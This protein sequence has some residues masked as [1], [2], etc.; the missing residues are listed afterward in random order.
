MK[1]QTLALLLSCGAIATAHAVIETTGGLLVDIDAA[2][3]SLLTDDTAVTTW[4]N[5][6]SQPDFRAINGTGG[7]TF[8][9]RG[10]IHVVRF[11]NTAAHTM[12]NGPLGSVPSSIL[13]G[14]DWS[15]EV[16]LFKEASGGGATIFS[17]TPR[18]GIT[19]NTGTVMELRPYDANNF[20]EH[21]GANNN[22][23]WGGV[24]D[25]N[26]PLYPYGQ[27][28]HIAVT[29]EADGRERLYCDGVMTTEAYLPGTNLQGDGG[30]FTIGAVRRR[31][32]GAWVNTFAGDVAQIR[33]HDGALTPG[34]VL[35]NYHSDNN[36]RYHRANAQ[37]AVW[38]TGGWLDLIPAAPDRGLWILGGDPLTVSAPLT[39]PHL[40][41]DNGALTIANGATLDVTAMNSFSFGY[42]NGS[43]F[44]LDI[45]DG[46]LAISTFN[47][48]TSYNISFGHCVGATATVT[49]GNGTTPAALTLPCNLVLGNYGGTADMTILNGS[50]LTSRSRV[51]VGDRG[52]TGT[53]DIEAGGTSISHDFII[54]ALGGTGTVNV[55]GTLISSNTLFIGENDGGTGTLT[56]APGGAVTAREIRPYN[57][58]GAGLLIFDGG[59]LIPTAN[60]ATAFITGNAQILITENGATFDTP[61][62]TFVTASVPIQN[63]T[64]ATPGTLTKTGPGELTLTGDLSALTGDIAVEGGAL[65]FN[66]S[67]LPDTFPGT[68]HLTDGAQIGYDSVGGATILL[69]CL[70][71][72]S[73]GTLRLY[74]NNAAETIDLSNHPGITLAPRGTVSQTTPITPHGNH[75]IFTPNGRFTYTPPIAD[76]AGGAPARV[77]VRGTTEDAQV[78]LTGDNAG[79]TGGITVESGGLAI[80]HPNAAGAAAA[81][82][83][84]LAEGTTLKLAAALPAD[85]LQTRVTDASRPLQILLTPES[86]ACDIDATRFPGCFLGTE[87]AGTVTFT[88]ALT[89]SGTDYLLGGG[90][91]PY[92]SPNNGLAIG[93]LTDAPG[94]AARRAVLGR[95]GLV[96][97]TNGNTHSGGT[98]VTNKAALYLCSDDGLGA[99]PA[100]LTLDG[101][102]LRSGSANF[103]LPAE[104]GILIGPAGAILH[105]WG[106]WTMTMLGNL[107]GTGPVRI[108]D[109]GSVIAAG[110]AN[111]YNGTVAIVSTLA[112][113]GI[114]NGPAFSWASTGGITNNGILALNTD[115]PATFADTI[116]G[117]GRIRKLGSGTLDITAAHPFTGRTVIEDGTLRLSGAGS[118]ANNSL[119]VNHG[120]LIIA[121]DAASG[122]TAAIGSVY[123]GTGTVRVAGSPASLLLLE[124]YDFPPGSLIVEN[125]GT[126]SAATLGALGTNDIALNSGT[127]ALSAAGVQAFDGFNTSEWQIN[128][129]EGNTATAFELIDGI[130]RLYLT[131]NAGGAAASAFL[132]K[133]VQVDKT[134]VAEFD[135]LTGAMSGPA[136][137]FAFILHTDPRGPTALG[138]SGGAIGMGSGTGIAAISKSIGFFINIYGNDSIGWAQNGV[139]GTATNNIF[140][141]ANA[142]QDGNVHFKLAYDGRTLTLTASQAG[143]TWT[144][145]RAANLI[146][147][148]GDTTAW[149]GFT[150]GTG[151][152]TCQQF[153]ANPTFACG[154]LPT[155]DLHPFTDANWQRNGDATFTDAA[156]LRITRSA[157]SLASAT[158]QKQKVDISRPFT[159]TARYWVSEKSGNPA[160]GAAFIFQN[161]SLTSIGPNGSNLGVGN[162]ATAYG[163]ALD[164]YSNSRDA[165]VW[166]AAGTRLAGYRYENLKTDGITLDSG[167]PVD[168]VISYDL[169]TMRITV[170]Q[171]G[172]T[173]S[174]ESP[175]IDL[176]DT[177]G[178]KE[179]YFGITGGTGGETAEQYVSD[180]TLSYNTMPA[181]PDN[182]YPNIINASGAS[183]LAIT[184]RA[185]ASDVAVNEITLAAAA[186]LAVPAADLP[187]TLTANTLTVNGAGASVTVASNGTLILG[188]TLRFA[189][190]ADLTLQGT[191][192][193]AGKIQ[194]VLSETVAGSRPLIDLTQAAGL[195]AEDFELV[196]PMPGAKL[197][198]R[199][200][201]LHVVND[202]GT[203]LILR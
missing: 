34:Q 169:N 3:L 16:W 52:G 25:S 38:T 89:P 84:T 15:L 200:G 173:V 120:E 94:G 202:I 68:I 186:S 36:A 99:L 156:T 165:L 75:Y 154:G 196:S 10:G 27:W 139:K 122:L 195:T 80:A 64:P 194:L 201:I 158:W 113:L 78:I 7:P 184:T 4:P 21:Y 70:T 14:N 67:A 20:V 46:T 63:D 153:I 45:A 151:G 189:P 5:N 13:G 137:G 159:L 188:D 69:S 144:L 92:A 177:F 22:I 77:T 42:G 72:T 143:Q 160:D 50:T 19:D 142:L 9:T 130:P 103:T 40:R 145:S 12:T 176:V 114:G 41:P 101:G 30:V 2:D 54:G 121:G 146:T 73:V 97:L 147:E 109:A 174:M 65:V 128:R 166:Y 170:T 140:G 49:L 183:T 88:G 81:K 152:S 117:T 59:T 74:G 98:L 187:Y 179:A 107:S 129:N 47:N 51:R 157:G 33:V 58:A 181:F 135:Y 180:V 86:A 115:A 138:A 62:N 85:F 123:T 95:E 66:N 127:L 199:D 150:G 131:P 141:T 108:T 203:I 24:R 124:G 23:P 175:V 93:T 32:D 168:V 35:N 61:A 6:G 136:D 125:G 116:H 178:A 11:N 148:L 110:A 104:R 83:I 134:W 39:L 132:T 31:T 26:I 133:C 190:G 112:T 96:C 53:L 161:T 8:Q 57:A 119:F 105:P 17:W 162:I 118:F 102:I 71:P 91:T 43:A 90:K 60:A 126:L 106:S 185:G 163:W 167:V 56:I 55:A 197:R 76:I 1:L 87:L 149:I 155:I 191:F 182:T 44:D 18:E 48:N 37:D 100:P 171:N 164:I 192:A 193:A 82:D 172:T 111:S 29:R 198:L 79:M 28:H